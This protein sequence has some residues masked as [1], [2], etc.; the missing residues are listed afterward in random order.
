[1][2]L[3]CFSAVIF[4]SLF[5]NLSRYLLVLWCVQMVP[6]FTRCFNPV[7]LHPSSWDHLGHAITIKMNVLLL[8]LAVLLLFSLPFRL[9]LIVWSI[10]HI[11]WL[12]RKT[13]AAYLYCEQPHFPPS[14]SVCC[15]QFCVPFLLPLVCLFTSLFPRN[16]QLYCYYHLW[17]LWPNCNV[18]A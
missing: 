17:Q 12:C 1:M 16:C 10:L 2:V 18:W 3:F 13:S 15:H 4:S 6:T 14:L 7:P 9:L 8:L 5:L 11:Q